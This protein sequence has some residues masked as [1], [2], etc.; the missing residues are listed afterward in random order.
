MSLLLYQ[1]VLWDITAHVQH[2]QDGGKKVSTDTEKFVSTLF[3]PNVRS[4]STIICGFLYSCG[5]FV[6]SVTVTLYPVII[7]ALLF[8]SLV[9]ACN[10]F[11]AKDKLYSTIMLYDRE[12]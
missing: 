2:L 1:V 11:G 4:D 6:P 12:K 3:L 9:K 5:L 8:V 7:L 10:M